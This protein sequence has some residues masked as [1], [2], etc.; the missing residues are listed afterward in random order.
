MASGE[1][2]EILQYVPFAS[3]VHPSFWHTLTKMKLE[4]DKLDENTKQINGRFSFRDDVGAIFEVDGTSFNKT[5]NNIKFYRNVTGTLMN[6]NTIENFKKIDKAALLNSVG[7]SIWAKI[8]SKSWVKNPSQLLNFIVLSYADLKKYH[9]FYWF[10]FPCPSQPIFYLKESVHITSVFNYHHINA[11][12]EGWR[13]LKRSQKSF[14]AFRMRGDEAIVMTL[15]EC[16]KSGEIYPPVTY[17]VFEDPNVD[18]S[19]GWP[20]RLF[21]AALYDHFPTIV[22]YELKVLGLRCNMHEIVNSSQIFTLI[23][24]PD[25]KSAES[26]GWVGWER[27]DK[28]NFGPKLANMSSSMDPKRLADTS[29]DLNIKLMKWRLVPDIDVD[30]MKN[31]RCLML[32]AGTLGCHVA[33]DL[34]A[35]GF[36]HFTFI[37]SGKVSFSNPTRQVLFNFQDC[38]AGGTHKAIAAAENLRLILPTVVTKGIPAHIPMPGHPVGESLKKE[39]LAHIT[40]ITHAI[41]RHDVIFLLL[42]TREARWLPALLGAYYGKIV[43]NAALGFDSYLVMRHGLGSLPQDT[44]QAAPFPQDTSQTAPLLQDT[45]QAALLPQDTSQAAPLPQ[46]TSQA[47]P[48]PQDTSQAGPLPQ[49]T[50]QAPPLPQDTSQAA[51]LPQDTLQAASL[52]QDPSQAAP[53]TQDPSQ[54]APLPQDPSQAA[55]L[56]QNP[57]Q[58]APLPQDTSQAAPLPQD[59]S[60]AAP[61]V[62][63][64]VP[65]IVPGSQLG[66]YFCNDV[67][68]P[69]NSLKDRTLDQQCTVTRPGVAAIAGAL[70]VELLVGL[71]QHPL[72]ADAPAICKLAD[73]D[74]AQD[75]EGVLGPIPHSIRGFL[76]SYTTVLPTCTKFKHCIACSDIVLQKYKE[77]GVEFLLKVFNSG[78][79]L[80]EITGLAELQLAAELTDIVTLSDEDEDANADENT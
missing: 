39:T 17:F 28:G 70:A 13:E 32:G 25:I 56:P 26:A 52:P 79:Y 10:A 21:L 60:T 71:L 7:E 44:S 34:L 18:H 66:C 58:A 54:A 68:A 62:G 77:E 3:F 72:K 40:V 9:Y 27:N 35:W 30:V 11:I 47:P 24:P 59:T 75:T 37:D 78:T 38:L 16:F 42:D 73:D 36:R 23:V 64:S 31:T 5:P 8:K 22:N 19:P 63:N 6:K 57:S 1:H 45:S 15:E 51:P 20:L 4:V 74:S 2:R 43:I 50:S 55:P 41:E 76:H 80:E 29:A 53:L 67:T 69:G 65:S 48:L 14:F 33:R 61:L 46:D 49:D 12:T